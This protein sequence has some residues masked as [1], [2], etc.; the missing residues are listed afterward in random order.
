MEKTKRSG[1]ESYSFSVNL[2]APQERYIKRVEARQRRG[3]APMRGRE[4]RRRREDRQH[5]T[6]LRKE[7]GDERGT[8]MRGEW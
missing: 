5:A 4:Q 3:G 6:R 7:T 8:V 2:Q 1:E